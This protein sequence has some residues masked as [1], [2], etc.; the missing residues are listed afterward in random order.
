M[1]YD[2]MSFNTSV[3]SKIIFVSEIHCNVALVVD[4]A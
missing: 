2:K 4:S 3:L 1:S